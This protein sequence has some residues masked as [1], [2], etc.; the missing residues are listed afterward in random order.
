MSFHQSFVARS[1]SKPAAPSDISCY[2][3]N[4]PFMTRIFAQELDK[5]LKQLPKLA[6]FG[7]GM[8]TPYFN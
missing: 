6:Q 1:S 2:E 4:A 5:M 3:H 7:T 8:S